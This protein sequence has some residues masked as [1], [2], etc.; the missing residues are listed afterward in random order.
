MRATLARCVPLTRAVPGL[1][2][3]LLLLGI[4]AARFWLAG[5]LTPR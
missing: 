5:L 2:L 4:I 3:V 1:L